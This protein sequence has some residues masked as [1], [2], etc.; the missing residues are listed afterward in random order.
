MRTEFYLEGSNIVTTDKFL[1]DI[2]TFLNSI[3]V[4][5]FNCLWPHGRIFTVVKKSKNS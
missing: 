3:S 4:M 5:E 2:Y 1:H